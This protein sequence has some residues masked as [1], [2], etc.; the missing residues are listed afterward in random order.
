MK[1]QVALLDVDS[2][3]VTQLLVI[4]YIRLFSLVCPVIAMDLSSDISSLLNFL[5]VVLHIEWLVKYLY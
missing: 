5:M 4:I 3:N 1:V 2:D